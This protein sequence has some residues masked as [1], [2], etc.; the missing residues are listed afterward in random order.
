[1]TRVSE[2]EAAAAAERAAKI[3]L[4]RDLASRSLGMVLEAVGPGTARLSMPVRDDMLNG[5]EICHGGYL[6]LLADSAFAFACNSYGRVT[7][8]AG[9][10]IEF[11]APVKRGEVLT[12]IARELWRS[13]RTGVYDIDVVN[14][15]G[16]RVALFRGRAHELSE[17]IEGS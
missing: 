7:V 14:G 12:A 6:F 13:R 11:L 10:T 5:H 9:A 2:A 3:M 4:E 15:D 16:R 17:R 8:A 1:M